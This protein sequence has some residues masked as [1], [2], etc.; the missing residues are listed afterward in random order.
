MRQ[1]QARAHKNHYIPR[2]ILRTFAD[3]EDRIWWTSTDGKWKEP[4]HSKC[5]NVFVETDLYTVRGESGN[6]D[7]NERMLAE[8]EGQWAGALRR[9][10]EL[11]S[12]GRD[13]NIEEGDALLALEY[14]LYAG[15]RT[16]EHLKWVMH[17]GEQT[18]REVID[19]VIEVRCSLGEADY[20]LLERNIRADLGSAQADRVKTDI[21]VLMHTRGLGIYKLEPGVGNFIIGSYGT[22][23]I[24][25]IE[26]EIKQEMYFTPVAPDMALFCT[27]Q[28]ECLVISRQGK[29]GIATLR[30]M[31]TATWNASQ[32]VAAASRE[33]LEAAE[34][35]ADQKL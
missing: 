19:K 29:E 30:K 9:M 5:A 31:N 28:P 24:S 6:S 27:N 18:P 15:I 2:F 7:Q 35:Q 17:G 13:D 25:L 11:V 3:D 34:K 4:R 22:A 16:P 8:K 21:A 14:Y 23:K 20:D 1:S 33:L 26:Q 32:W 10:R 12:E